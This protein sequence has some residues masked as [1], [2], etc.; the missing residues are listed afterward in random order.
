MSTEQ[1]NDDEQIT[2]ILNHYHEIAKNISQSIGYDVIINPED[3]FEYAKNI[4]RGLLHNKQKYGEMFCPCKPGLINKTIQ[5]DKGVI[6][7]S[8]CKCYDCEREI[9]KKGSCCCVLFIKK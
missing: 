9:Q 8:V 4:I 3:N 5:T 7:R 6:Y 1:F 2:L